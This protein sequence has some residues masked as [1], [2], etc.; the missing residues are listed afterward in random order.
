[1]TWTPHT[2]GSKYQATKDWKPKDVNKAVRADIAAAVK[3]GQLPAAKYSVRTPH[4]GSV[5][6]T[7]SGLPFQVRTPHYNPNAAGNDPVRFWQTPQARAL[8]TAVEAIANAYNFDD[9]DSMTDYFHNRFYLHVNLDCG[10]EREDLE[11]LEK[12]TKAR[13]SL[14][15][16]GGR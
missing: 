1:M 4:H 15:L 2:L 14:R 16:V 10:T 12:F 6:I 11:A 7:V 8:Q 13:P 5:D 3:A 9:S